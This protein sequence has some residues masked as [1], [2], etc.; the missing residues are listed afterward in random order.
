LYKYTKTKL[1][2]FLRANSWAALCA[3]HSAV[4]SNRSVTW[5]AMSVDSVHALFL[6]KIK[7]TNR[8]YD[9]V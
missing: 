5:C 4:D 6:H 7:L 1:L 2:G 9:V 8:D 3:A